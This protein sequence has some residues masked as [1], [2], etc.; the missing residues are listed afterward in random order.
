[1]TFS[2]SLSTRTL[3]NSMT[4]VYFFHC[5]FTS[6]WREVLPIAAARQRP[7]PSHVQKLASENRAE[8]IADALGTAPETSYPRRPSAAPEERGGQDHPVASRRGRRRR[9]RGRYRCAAGSGPEGEICSGTA[10]RPPHCASRRR[11]AERRQLAR[12]ITSMMSAAAHAQASR[13]YGRRLARHR[14]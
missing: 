14:L 5:R 7:Y 2:S 9:G 6:V 8:P 13:P 1:M 3:P 4:N 12:R 10:G 11:C